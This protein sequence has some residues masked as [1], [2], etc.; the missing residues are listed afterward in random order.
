[1][2]SQQASQL[3]LGGAGLPG[4]AGAMP[5]D[6]AQL[7]VILRGNIGQGNLIDPQQVGQQLT[8]QFVGL[9][10]A[11]TMAPAAK[12]VLTAPFPGARSRSYSQRYVPVA[13]MT[14]RNGC[15]ARIVSRI[16]CR[17]WQLIRRTSNELPSSFT[18]AITTVSRCKSI[19][20]C[21]MIGLLVGGTTQA[22]TDVIVDL[23]PGDFLARGGYSI[24][25]RQPT[26][27]LFLCA[28]VNWPA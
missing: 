20:T 9:A 21:H 26:D 3:R 2:S 11:C 28:M 1:M 22:S 12:G 23:E 25:T 17:S 18:A 10:A 15:S 4:E 5:R 6:V 7:L 19:P 14:A 27:G 16:T 24:T 13:S 8:I